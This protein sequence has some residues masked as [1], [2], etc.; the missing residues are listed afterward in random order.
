[1]KK[2]T[3]A[4]VLG[5]GALFAAACGDK[6]GEKGAASGEAKA[7]GDSVGVAECD[8]YFKKMEACLGKMPAEA[9]K[10]YE[11]TMKQ[12]KDAWK[13]LAATPQ[14]KEG[15]KTACKT[16]VDSIAQMPQCK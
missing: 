3:L 14:G 16:A 4:L 13:Q 7:S 8:D 10:T 6:G 9:K 12:N 1:M 2:I 15:L 5:A 11:D